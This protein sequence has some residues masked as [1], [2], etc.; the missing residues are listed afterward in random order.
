M[1]VSH[2]DFWLNSTLEM[3]QG[4]KRNELE[5]FTALVVESSSFRWTRVLVAW[6]A[7]PDMCYWE[8]TR[9]PKY[10]REEYWK[11]GGMLH[12]N[13]ETQPMIR[14]PLPLLNIVVKM[15]PKHTT[16]LFFATCKYC[17]NRK[18]WFDVSSQNMSQ[19]SVGPGGFLHKFWTCTGCFVY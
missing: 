1:T 17:A 6:S 18:L 10:Q 11:G 16:V 2:A 7:R 5:C 8:T 14:K 4:D 13:L 15:S 19:S 12:E 3:S 9:T